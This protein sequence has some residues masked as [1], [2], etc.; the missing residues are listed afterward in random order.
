MQQPAEKPVLYLV[1]WLH[2]TLLPSCRFVYGPK[3][4]FCCSLIHNLTAMFGGT[5]VKGWIEQIENLAAISTTQPQA[6]Y[7]AFFH[8]TK[9]KWTHLCM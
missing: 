4:K 9:N 3:F 7:A 5:K 8:D 2:L 6:I 1:P